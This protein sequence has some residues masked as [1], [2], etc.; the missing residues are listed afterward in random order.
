MAYLQDRGEFNKL[1]NELYGKTWVTFCKRPFGGPEQIL[2]YLSRYTH[3][4][5]ISNHR[6]KKVEDGRVYFQWKNY[7]KGGKQEETSLEVF[8][9]IRRFL[10][11]VLPKGYFKIRY[12]GILASRNRHKLW[13]AQEILGNSEEVQERKNEEREKSFEEW[14]L[15]LTGIQPGICP[16]CKKGRLIPKAQ[17][18]PAP[19]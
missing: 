19:P 1:Q 18:A 16:Y 2:E 10:L 7:R 6:L 12:Y 3:R 11:H 5:A 15:E 13:T 17:L 9:F 4:V 8:E 14:F